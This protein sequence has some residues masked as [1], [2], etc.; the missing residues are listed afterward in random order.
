MLSHPQLVLIHLEQVRS[1]E[2][3]HLPLQP[4][5]AK[6]VGRRTTT[7]ALRVLNTKEKREEKKVLILLL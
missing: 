6:Q 7:V 2:P 3:I 4:Y 5:M 1:S